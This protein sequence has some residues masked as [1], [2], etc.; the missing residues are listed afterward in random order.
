[1]KDHCSQEAGRLSAAP[2]VSAAPQR[3][4]IRLRPQEALSQAP[5]LPA[6]CTGRCGRC[7]AICP[8]E[9][10][11]VRRAMARLHNPAWMFGEFRRPRGWV[12]EAT[13]SVGEYGWNRRERRVGV[14]MNNSSH[15]KQ[16]FTK[17]KQRRHPN[18][19]RLTGLHCAWSTGISI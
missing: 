5:Q 17:K 1:M 9:Y 6:I 12:S 8:P 3:A 15:P 2:H 13:S 14:D 19:E 16:V 10:C 18:Q 11:G 4:K 7:G